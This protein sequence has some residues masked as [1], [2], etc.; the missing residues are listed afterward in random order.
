[1]EIGFPKLLNQGTPV[2]VGTIIGRPMAAPAKAG[3]SNQAFDIDG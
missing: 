1:M 3:S 2:Q